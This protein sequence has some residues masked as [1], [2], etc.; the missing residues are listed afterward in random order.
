MA[1]AAPRLEPSRVELNLN[2]TQVRL[3][4]LERQEWWRWVIAFIV[5][6]ALTVGLFV[7]AIPVAGGRNWIEQAEL[8]SAL[9]GLL[10]LILV[11]DVFVVYQQMVITRLRRDLAT[12]LRVVT[13]LETLKKADDGANGKQKER[14]RIRRSGL[15][16]RVRVITAREEKPVHGWMRDINEDGLGAVIPCS[17]SINERVTIEFSLEDGQDHSASATVRHCHGFHYGFDFVSI[18]PSLRDAIARQ[19][20]RNA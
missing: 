3:D 1:T 10:A 4:Q 17:L 11:F 6:F 2:Q 15:D 19:C 14:R 9:R 12:Q 18:E 16:R 7:L 5:M 20:E 8:N 13:T